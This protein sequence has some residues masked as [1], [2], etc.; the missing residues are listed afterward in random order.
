[1]EFNITWDQHVGGDHR[2]M[3]AGIRSLVIARSTSSSMM[4][5]AD[6]MVQIRNVS[7]RLQQDV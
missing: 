2:L 7:H 6:L 4:P 5:F 1:M 3:A